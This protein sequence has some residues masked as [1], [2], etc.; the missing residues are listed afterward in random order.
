MTAGPGRARLLHAQLLDHVQKF[1]HV[2]TC[3]R[4]K[5]PKYDAP[6]TRKV[7]PRSHSVPFAGLCDA[8][9]LTRGAAHPM[10]P[11]A[12][13]KAAYLSEEPAED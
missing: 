13:A 7:S 12:R 10:S 2:T 1:G 9:I 11:S 4:V 6:G 5:V 8:L 3:L